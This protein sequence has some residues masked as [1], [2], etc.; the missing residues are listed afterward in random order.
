MVLLSL[1][2]EF[3]YPYNLCW[4]S[5]IYAILCAFGNFSVPNL[6]SEFL[7]F[8]PASNNILLFF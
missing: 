7:D 4:P 8:E 2:L 1:N 5:I 6:E 3:A